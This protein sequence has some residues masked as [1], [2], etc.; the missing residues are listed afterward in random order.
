VGNG[1]LFCFRED[2]AGQIQ[3]MI[4]ILFSYYGETAALINKKGVLVS[5]D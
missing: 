5:D 4:L 3:L 1:L 2:E